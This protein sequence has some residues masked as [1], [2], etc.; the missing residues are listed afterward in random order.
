MIVFPKIYPGSNARRA[1]SGWISLLD[2]RVITNPAFLH[3]PGFHDS[4]LIKLKLRSWFLKFRPA[5]PCIVLEAPDLCET[6]DGP[7]ST[8]ANQETQDVDAR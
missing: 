3:P 8:G 2:H 6:L 5:L 7:A 1:D 4:P